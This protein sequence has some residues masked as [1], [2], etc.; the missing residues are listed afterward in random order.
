MNN[1]DHKVKAVIAAEIIK[2]LES[3]NC[4][5]NESKEILDFTLSRIESKDKVNK[6]WE[7]KS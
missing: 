7:V 4:N 5:V 3:Y 1:E 6:A 2:I